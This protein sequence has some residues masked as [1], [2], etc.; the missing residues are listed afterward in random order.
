MRD[1]PILFSALMVR[2]ILE[3]RKTQTRRVV[4][5]QAESSLGLW[6][7]TV[8]G[9]ASAKDRHGKA[10]ASHSHHRCLSFGRP[11]GAGVIVRAQARL[12]RKIDHGAFGS[13]LGPNGRI[14]LYL[15]LANQLR[16]LLPRLSDI[17]T[18]C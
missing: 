11:R 17:S 14:G 9:G 7:P 4:K 5:L 8:I 12:T 10:R 3:S 2:A 1:L 6:E 15:P 13:R 16:V 18:P